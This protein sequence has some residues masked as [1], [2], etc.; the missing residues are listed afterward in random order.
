MSNI[1]WANIFTSVG[2]V[3]AVVTA[4]GLTVIDRRRRESDMKRTR[5]QDATS[6]SAVL[7]ENEQPGSLRALSF[8]RADPPS[9]EV[10]NGGSQPILEVQVIVA[11]DST[12][13]V[14]LTSYGWSWNADQGGRILLLQSGESQRLEGRIVFVG[15]NPGPEPKPHVP[16]FAKDRLI[17]T[18]TWTDT[19][20][21]K[22]KK[23]GAHPPAMNYDR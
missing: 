6:V 20:D 1:H 5:R 13:D 2:T 23:V 17:I 16:N 21:H 3:G 10:T 12:H 15:D 8:G 19:A 11:L 14:T 18:T 7:V 9:I 22:W 4:V